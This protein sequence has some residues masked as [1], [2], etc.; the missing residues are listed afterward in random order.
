MNFLRSARRL[1]PVAFGL[2]CLALVAAVSGCQ[3]P[4]DHYTN[5]LQTPLPPEMQP[6]KEISKVALPAYTVEPPDM[7]SI[8][9]LKMVP[10]P[11]YRIDVYDVLQIRSSFALPDQPINDFYIVEAEGVVNLGPAYGSIRVV[12]MTIDEATA[13]IRAKLGE[14]LT[15]PDVSV[16]LARAA[17]TQPVS[18]QYLVAP[19]GTI[20]LKMYGSIPVAGKTLEQIKLD[21]QKRLEQYFDSPEVSVDVLGYNSKVYYVITDGAGMGDNVRRVPITGNETVLDAVSQVG[22][23]SQV[24]SKEVWIA[25]PAPGDFGCEQIMPVDYVAITRGGATA[26]NY[27]IM[28]GDRV[29]IADDSMV[30]MNNV[31]G[32]FTA[33]IERLLGLTGLGSSTVRN[34]QTTGRNYNRTRSGF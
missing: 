19:D 29:F 5:T 13:N 25:R 20:N 33:P 2:L 26:T 10:K 31:L 3:Q 24:S 7:V 6:P 28:P 17:S 22:G 1:P 14:V 12:G 4:F 27:Q 21:V 18:G 32:K 11:P 9:M 30:G 34:L 8:D 23:L 16:Q 15:Q